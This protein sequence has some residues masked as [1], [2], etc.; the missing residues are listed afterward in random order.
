MNVVIADDSRAMRMIVRKTIREAGYGHA[1]VREAEDGAA[2]LELI[3][4]W[5]PDLLMTDWNMPNMGGLEL[6]KALQS[7]RFGGACG[8][9]SS[10][11]TPEMRAAANEA[12]ARF[13]IQK[14]FT[15]HSFQQALMSVGFKPANAVMS[16]G[17]SAAS[18]TV[19]ADGIRAS[20][21][22]VYKRDLKISGAEPINVRD[23]GLCAYGVYELD[24]NAQ[25]FV[26]MEVSLAVSLA[27]A[28]SLI[29]RGVAEAAAKS[30]VVDEDLRGN[31][32]EAFNLMC[33]AAG[34]GGKA[35]Q[36]T[37][38]DIA[39]EIPLF[40]RAFSRKC[41]RADVHVAVPGY[42]EGRMCL[43]AK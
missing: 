40:L 6:L 10:A 29:P 34:A 14:P 24:G 22:G 35:A 38:V 30:G 32:H 23:T 12:G 36:L 39:G 33:R 7:D 26:I 2:A 3:R 8:V 11:A 37:K 42:G 17:G 43:A 31:L 16:G 41:R 18:F 19:S 21:A 20:L 4:S 5:A 15:P 27:A 25:G 13:V 1:E 9:V 28:L